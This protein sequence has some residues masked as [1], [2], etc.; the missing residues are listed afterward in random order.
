V[1]VAVAT[2]LGAVLL[3]SV[4]AL[5]F[6][7]LAAWLQVAASTTDVGGVA[8]LLV[9]GVLG[10]KLGTVL[11]HRI[12]QRWV[13]YLFTLVMLLSAVDLLVLGLK[14]APPLPAAPGVPPVWSYPMMGA[15]AGLFSGMLG[16]G[17]GALVVLV[18]SALFHTPVL[19]A[20]PIALAVNITNAAAGVAAQWSS[21]QI[22]WSEVRA[23]V[24]FALVGV[25]FGTGLALV[26]PPDAL[27]VVFALF[28]IIMGISLVR[29]AHTL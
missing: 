17:G 16:I 22:L 6:H 14:L 11:L 12:P 2:S 13:M 5:A 4:A 15:A 24:P 23:L 3:L 19:G 28:F 18:M 20:L 8:L 10:S 7:L 21:G 25:G 1:R 29:K 9:A 27:R 26:L